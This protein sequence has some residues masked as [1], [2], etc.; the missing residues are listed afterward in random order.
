MRSLRSPRSAET[1]RAVLAVGKTAL[2]RGFPLDPYAYPT[3]GIPIFSPVGDRVEPAMVYAIA[4]Q[5]SAFN[6]RGRLDAPARA[7]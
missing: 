6:P 3:F 2:Q 7:A 4:R 1:P 5:E